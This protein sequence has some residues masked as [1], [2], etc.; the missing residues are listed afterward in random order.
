[1]PNLQNRNNRRKK[2]ESSQT[3]II[4]HITKEML[5]KARTMAENGASRA[6][7]EQAIAQMQAE[8]N[9][10][11]MPAVQEPQAEPDARRII[12]TSRPRYTEEERKALLEQMQKEQEQ[13]EAARREEATKRTARPAWNFS[14]PKPHRP[15]AVPE[16]VQEKSTSS[17]PVASASEQSA[18]SAPTQTVE[19][20]RTPV[21]AVPEEPT[22]TMEP[23][24]PV[25]AEEPAEKPAQ[26]PKPV[27]KP[28]PAPQPATPRRHAGVLRSRT[29]AEAEL[30]E[31][32]R[33]DHIWLSNPV[34]VRGLGL[35][36]VVG[37]AL[38]GERAL[39]LC[40]ACLLLVTFTRVLAVAVCHL[41]KNRFRPLIYCYVAALLYIPVYILLYEL[42][43][44]N[45]TMLG[46]YLPILVVEPAIVKRMEF[47]EL[48]PIRD[49]WRHGFNNGLGMCAALLIVGCLR[50]FL[51]TG[52]VFGHPL[53]HA[54]LLPLAAQPAGGFVLVGVIAAVWCAVANAYTEYKREEVRRLYADRK[55]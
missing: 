7:I 42:F 50:E 17:E 3:L 43:G 22:R 51:A 55:R 12:P 30:N 24:H 13:R 14:V 28:Q 38:D 44:N 16:P 6:E 36:P 34:M 48:E 45:L 21:Q 25:A 8:K 2:D 41:S 26:S 31:K 29:E 27:A 32:I 23:V 5:E 35:A 20:P 54:A 46:I 52:A 49:A 39:I 53:V 10:T 4:P 33:S 9:G 47:T 1:M 11:A 15:A 19:M 37:A 18:P 40:V